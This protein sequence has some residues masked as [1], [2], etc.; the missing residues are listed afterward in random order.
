D[1]R[2]CRGRR[3]CRR[4]R[5]HR[6]DGRAW[7]T[8]GS[9]RDDRRPL[10][11]AGLSSLYRLPRVRRRRGSG[12]GCSLE[13]RFA[14]LGSKT[15]E[16]AGLGDADV[17]HEAASLDLAGP[18]KRLENGQHLHLADDLVRLRLYKQLS[19]GDTTTLEMVLDL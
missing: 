6:A 4:P 14:L 19:Q 12:P 17:L 9:A 1:A 5:A 3:M 18:G 10:P 7:S 11:G 13:E 15:L 2:R 16:P 8:K